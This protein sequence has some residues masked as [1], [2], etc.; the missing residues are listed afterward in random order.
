MSLHCILKSMGCKF[1][2]T[3][4]RYY[5]SVKIIVQ[6]KAMVLI[7]VTFFYFLYRI[8]AIL[9][10]ISSALSSFIYHMPISKTLQT[11]LL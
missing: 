9:K 6:N 8:S 4:L 3:A 5:Y 7:F 1:L 2:I 10:N 11:L